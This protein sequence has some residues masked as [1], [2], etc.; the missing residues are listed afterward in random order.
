MAST[1]SSPFASL[2]APSPASK[3][4]ENDCLDVVDGSVGDMKKL[5][6][7]PPAEPPY[8]SLP[9]ASTST[10]DDIG[11][12]L[13]H[14]SFTG[15]KLLEHAPPSETMPSPGSRRLEGPSVVSAIN[16]DITPG[17]FPMAPS[18][19]TSTSRSPISSYDTTRE[20]TNEESKEEGNASN[21][22]ADSGVYTVEAQLV[23][24][25]NKEETIMVAEA[26]FVRTKWYQR[27]M[28]FFGACLVRVRSCCCGGGTCCSTTTC[29]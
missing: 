21:M 4:N 16:Q 14:G 12:G 19:N 9:S 2:Q 22:A 23:L 20:F 10:N 29:G 18:G 6:H 13:A 3:V 11:R 24:Y 26:E 8:A 7:A 1:Y 27:Q 17:A 28:D 5:E 15:T 25:G